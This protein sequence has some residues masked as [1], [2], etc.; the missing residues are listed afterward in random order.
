[1]RARTALTS[2]LL[3]VAGCVGFNLVTA[4]PANAYYYPQ[5]GWHATSVFADG[6]TR[7]TTVIDCQS[8]IIANMGGGGQVAMP[9]TGV[10][11]GMG[12]EVNLDSGHPRVGESF[13]IRVWARSISTPCGFQGVVPVFTLPPGLT[14]DMSGHT[15]CLFDGVEENA[16]TCPQPGSA[17]FQSASAT[18]GQP[19]SWQI[20]CGYASGCYNT[21][22]WPT[23]GG[24]G[25]E[26]AI[27]VKSTGT[28][29]GTIGGG[30]VINTEDVPRMVPL[31]AP[32][33]VFAADA[34]TG[35][36]PP[37]APGNPT[38]QDPGYAYRVRYDNPSTKTSAAYELNPSLAT[39]HG[40][41]SRAEVFTNHV[42][43]EV[44]FARD[45][46]R[47]KVEALPTSA[48]A[49]VNNTSQVQQMVSGTIDNSG[50]SF[51]SE[52][53]WRASGAGSSPGMGVAPGT[54]Y[55]WRYGFIAEPAGTTL[56]TAKITW[57]SVQ[58]F[59]TP[60]TGLTCNGLTATV[61]IGLNEL[62]TA[63]D[64]VIVGTPGNDSING[65]GGNDTICGGG[66]AD[67]INGGAGNDK[68][69]G[70]GGADTLVGGDGNDTL[71][72]GD[73][74][75]VLLPG[76][77]ADTAFGEAGKDTVSYTDIT[78]PYA[79]QTAPYTGVWVCS[80]NCGSG[81][82][83]VAG[84]AGLDQIGANNPTQGRIPWPERI[85]GTAFNDVID[86]LESATVLV[87]GN[88]DDQLRGGPG[89][90]V[91]QPGKGHDVVTGG[92]GDTVSYADATSGVIAKLGAPISGSDVL[93]GVTR[94]VGGPGADKLTG[95][96]G[97]DRI[98]GGGGNDVIAGQGGADALT[99]GAGNDL[100]RGDAGN[101]AVTGGS[102]GDRLYG[103]AGNDGL[104]GDS[105]NDRLYGD[106]GADRLSGGTGK[107][108][109]VGAS[110]RDRC[111][112]GSQRDVG[113]KCEVRRRIP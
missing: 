39:A 44:V 50:S 60:A 23:V 12:T 28:V 9:S 17:K 88:G 45:T 13:H 62:P 78:V 20:L 47:A 34:G 24:H 112:G 43:G 29:N 102:G 18:T 48:Q 10:V 57:G 40:V 96:P 81:F 67:S 55:Y 82:T 42:P 66:G 71:R 6:A 105:G 95:T 74:D 91:F 19:N 49:L 80:D 16:A 100:I 26:I 11:T 92:P 14:V 73:G 75:D 33:N 84:A 87:G 106:A 25:V 70:E 3:I 51:L 97:A 31:Q 32:L 37:P 113:V 99:G 89:A 85:I 4:V 68:L 108:R 58:S 109:L 76:L 27:P 111:D 63:G 46:T 2:L 83:N 41:L 1:M 90:D 15:V 107:D 59:S 110:G 93:S 7:S 94:L 53:D 104:T 38:V 101:D 64:D 61:A 52:F 77:G 56:A 21:N 69:Y 103:G 98:S 79:S 72:G 35:T 8:L 22:Y 54:T 30:A 36:A 5:D 65:L 86:P